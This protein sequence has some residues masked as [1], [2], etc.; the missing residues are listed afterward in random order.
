LNLLSVNELAPP[1]HLFEKKVELEG[2]APVEKMDNE[3]SNGL[4][5]VGG[6]P[7]AKVDGK[8]DQMEDETTNGKQRGRGLENDEHY[9]CYFNAILM[10]LS[11]LGELQTVLQQRKTERE[12]KQSSDKVITLQTREEAQSQLTAES[13]LGEALAR[14][15]TMMTC[16]E[17]ELTSAREHA[18]TARTLLANHI[19]N[20]SDELKRIFASGVQA[21]ASEWLNAL[22]GM[23]PEI[24]YLFDFGITLYRGCNSCQK[25]SQGLTY[26][27][28]S[29]SIQEGRYENLAEAMQ[30]SRL[31]IQTDAYRTVCTACS[32]APTAWI[33]YDAITSPA[34]QYMIIDN[35]Q[36]T[37]SCTL[38]P[39][40]ITL[41]L[42][43]L[44]GTTTNNTY[45]LAEEVL[46]QRHSAYSGHYVHRHH[47][48]NDSIDR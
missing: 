27:T 6:G 41:R 35:S 47:N 13:L 2:G 44:G 10:S 32:N 29:V 12:K 18:N 9:K 21:S 19:R 26:K 28:A 24:S 20:S 40:V 36:N 8:R 48:K 25:T 37:N 33:V 17:K 1:L 16:D 5:I 42:G 39:S 45:R 22:M 38:F 15:A 23:L 3:G 34:P 7:K 46:H 4:K 11:G 14:I 43:K 31:T 30:R